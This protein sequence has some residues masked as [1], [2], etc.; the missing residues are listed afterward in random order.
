MV[1]DLFHLKVISTVIDQCDAL[2]NTLHERHGVTKFSASG[3]T[4]DLVALSGERW[5]DAARV[6]QLAAKHGLS[7]PATAQVQFIAGARKAL[8][9]LPVQVF[10]SPE[11]RDA[12]LGAA[13]GALDRAIDQEEGL[14]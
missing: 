13:Q 11:A 4:A 6:G 1:S 10:Q 2:A 3:V 9:D 7:E 12:V 14:A 5:I 8:S